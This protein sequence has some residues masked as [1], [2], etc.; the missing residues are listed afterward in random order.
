MDTADNFLNFLHLQKSPAMLSLLQGCCTSLFWLS[1]FKADLDQ[2]ALQDDTFSLLDQ[3]SA[4]LKAGH[5]TTGTVYT[6][7]CCP[8]ICGCNLNGPLHGGCFMRS[9]PKCAQDDRQEASKHFI[10][11]PQECF[12]SRYFQ[13]LPLEAEPLHRIQ[14]WA[15]TIVLP[16]N[17]QKCLC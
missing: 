15:N 5:M 3:R 13:M 14:L 11:I 4:F 8:Q 2:A 6:A 7:S 1:V 16:S 9:G 12:S 17:K 10:Q